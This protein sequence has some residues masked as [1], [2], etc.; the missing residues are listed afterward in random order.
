MLEGIGSSVA[1]ED[2]RG[3]GGFEG[4]GVCGA[5]EHKSVHAHHF[6]TAHT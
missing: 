3:G 1:P 5:P 2:R 4:W 6:T